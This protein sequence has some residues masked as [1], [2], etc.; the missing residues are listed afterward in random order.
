LADITENHTLK[1]KAIL[2]LAN[3]CKILNKFKHSKIF[4][5]KAL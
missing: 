5:K 1:V 3:T 2:E 4:L